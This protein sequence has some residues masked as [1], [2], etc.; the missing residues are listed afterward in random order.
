MRK[1]LGIIEGE[2]VRPSHIDV[3]ADAS[4]TRELEI[5]YPR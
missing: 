5:K 4:Q 2:A 1:Y 3:A